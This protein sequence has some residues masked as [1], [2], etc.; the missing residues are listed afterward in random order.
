M[1]ADSFVVNRTACKFLKNPKTAAILS[2]IVYWYAPSKNGQPKLRANQDG[3]LCL[4]KANKEWEGE[5]G[6]G[7]SS[8]R[9]CIERLEELG[10]IT[11]EPHPFDGSPKNHIWLNLNKIYELMPELAEDPE[12]FKTDKSNCSERSSRSAHYEQVQLPKVS[13]SITSN[14]TINTSN[15]HNNEDDAEVDGSNRVW[16]EYQ[17]ALD[18]FR[19]SF[20]CSEESV[21][22]ALKGLEVECR[23]RVLKEATAVVQ[24]KMSQIKRLSPYALKVLSNKVSEYLSGQVK[25]S[26]LMSA[27]KE[28]SELLRQLSIEPPARISI[29]LQRYSVQSVRELSNDEKEDFIRYLREGLDKAS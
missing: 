16:F 22:Q 18:C 15:P 1:T 19:Q 9:R 17:T 28:I 8:A 20:Q 24:S 12:F 10:I 2:K 14:T 27:E 29:L 13:K 21:S 4:V 25:E 23:V 5:C 11:V 6:V 3:I 26:N 7:Y